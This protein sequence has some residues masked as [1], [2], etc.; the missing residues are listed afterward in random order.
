MKRFSY[1]VAALL[2]VA[3][4][5]SCGGGDLEDGLY[6]EMKTSKGTIVLRL[7][8][9][10]VPMIVA[11]F[12]GLAEGSIRSQESDRKAF[13]DGL[14]FFRVEEDF[15]IQSGDPLNE[16]SGGPGYTLPDEFDPT[17][18]HDGP[19]VISMANRGPNTNGS[20]FFITHVATPWL[21]DA[22]SVFGRVVEGQ[23]VVDAIEQGDKIIR[24]RIRRQGDKAKSFVVAQE[25][26]E[27]L[28]ASMWKRIETERALMRRETEAEIAQRW[29][30]TVAT[31]S[32]LR[33]EILVAGTGAKPAA[34]AK[35]TCHYTGRFLDGKVFDSSV[36]RGEAAEFRVTDVI[37][38]W[39]QTLV[40]M[41]RGEKRLVIIPPE[42]AYGER[43]YPGVIPPNSFLVFELELLSF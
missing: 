6:A 5:S 40:D 21:D 41:R 24:V 36:E 9:E 4:I 31:S 30:N 35:V 26:F 28:V 32:G 8:Y 3:A 15:M 22:H 10:K 39:Q 38:G 33:Y 37:P 13:Y 20:Q 1:L 43:G 18:R 7:E 25:D 14:L 42:L 17:L 34:G 23:E 11:N 27:A 29:P 16:G 2:C 19:G 12:V